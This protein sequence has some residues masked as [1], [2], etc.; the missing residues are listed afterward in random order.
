MADISVS[1]GS[2]RE[3]TQQ[4][5]TRILEIVQGLPEGEQEIRL[6]LPL[7]IYDPEVKFYSQIKNTFWHLR[8]PGATATLEQIETISAAIGV[9]IRAIAKDPAWVVEVLGPALEESASG[10]EGEPHA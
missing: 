6:R 4:Q 1:A 9:A 10:V 5:L 7:N 3:T 8:L 2:E